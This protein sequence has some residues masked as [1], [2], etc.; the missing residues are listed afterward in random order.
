[1]RSLQ[2]VR[3]HS[4]SILKGIGGI[5]GESR[6]LKKYGAAYGGGAFWRAT[7][8]WVVTINNCKRAPVL[9]NKNFGYISNNIIWKYN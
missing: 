4:L 2:T 3:T 8:L 5:P 1:M 6:I 7:R 9:K